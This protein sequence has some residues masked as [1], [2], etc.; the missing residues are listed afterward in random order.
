M[1][2][3]CV[4]R[5]YMV[6][7]FTQHEVELN[8]LK[9]QIF[10][11]SDFPFP[12]S[13]LES[14][15]PPWPLLPYLLRSVIKPCQFT[16]QHIPRVSPHSSNWSSCLGLLLLKSILSPTIDKGCSSPALVS[17]HF[18]QKAQMVP[19]W[20]R[21]KLTLSSIQGK[22]APIWPLIYLLQLFLLAHAS[23]LLPH[24]ALPNGHS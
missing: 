15:R 22:P 7:I 21:T 19:Q 16:P 8:H 18:P 3:H 11:T 24:C 6:C 20:L 4:K 13:R 9:L 2:N 17:L 23:I 12:H 14:V 10:P 5:H 1:R